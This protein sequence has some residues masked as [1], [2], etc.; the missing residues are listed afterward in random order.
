MLETI[1]R[2]NLTFDN[3]SKQ[4]KSSINDNSLSV[5]VDKLLNQ[6]QILGHLFHLKVIKRKDLSGL[7]YEIISI[8]RCDAVRKY[9]NYLNSEYQ[10][11][12]GIH[13][14]HFDYFNKIYIAFEYDKKQKDTYPLNMSSNSS[15]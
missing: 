6:F 14:E 5:K 7:E 10:H 4:I 12:S 8:G 1:Y 13:H 11:I 2:N 9:I 15:M 3:E